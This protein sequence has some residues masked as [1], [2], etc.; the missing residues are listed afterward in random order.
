MIYSIIIYRRIT[1]SSTISEAYS[2]FV[3]F[4][5]RG[6]LRFCYR[7]F[8]PYSTIDGI[9]F[10]FFLASMDSCIKSSISHL[11]LMYPIL[12]YRWILGFH[13]LFWKLDFRNQYYLYFLH[14]DMSP[15]LSWYRWNILYS[16]IAESFLFSYTSWI[17]LFMYRWDISP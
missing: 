4:T 6:C 8:I 12:R 11:Y 13:S 17:L 2:R 15:F 9:L 1:F 16:S 5:I 14:I 7:W 10:K 3:I